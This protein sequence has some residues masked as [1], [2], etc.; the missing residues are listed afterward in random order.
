M[1]ISIYENKSH[2]DVEIKKVHEIEEVLSF[3]DME[4]LLLINWFYRKDG[5]LYKD[6][7]LESKCFIEFSGEEFYDIIKCLGLVLDNDEYDA[8]NVLALYYFPLSIPYY[9]NGDKSMFGEEYYNSLERLL[10]G[11]KS[12]MRDLTVNNRERLFYY[13]IK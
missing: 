13:N 6:T 1:M 3:T 9:I 4:A 12:V 11:L 7:F 10:G 8:D 2:N 5:G